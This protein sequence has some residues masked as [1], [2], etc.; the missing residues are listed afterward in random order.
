MQFLCRTALVGLIFVSLAKLVAAQDAPPTPVRYDVDLSDA[1]NHHVTITLSADATGPETEVMMATWTPGSYLIRE[2]ARHID[3]I[4][5]FDPNGKELAIHKTQKNRWKID[6]GEHK[7]FSLRYRIYARERSVR[8][9]WVTEDYAVLNGAPTFITLPTH[10][11][12]AH[13]VTLKLPKPWKRSAT[14]LQTTGS[15][16][17]AY[18]AKDFDELVDSPIVAG[19]MT[20]YPFSVAGKEHQLVNVNDR[21]YWNGSRAVRDL[22]TMVEEHHRLWGNIPYERYLF[23]NV[24]CGGGGGLEHDNSCLLMTSRWSSLSEGGH[25]RWLSLASHE[26]FHTWNVRRLRPK[27]LVKYDYEAEVYTPSLWI[28]EGVTSYYQDLILVRAGL[29]K[30]SEFLSTMSN[31]IGRLQMTE[32]RLRQSLRDSSHDAWIKFYRPDENSRKT[33]ISYYGKGAVVAGLLDAKIRYASGGKHSLDD[34]MRKL[35]EN[36]SGDRGFLPSDFRKI[37]SDLAGVDLNPWF[38]TAVDSTD[39]LDYQELCDCFGLK[40]GNL[41]PTPAKSNTE[42]KP[43]K[44]PND[45][46]EKTTD[47]VAKEKNDD[48]K[49]AKP[50]PWIGVGTRTDNGR[51][52]VSS[53]ETNSP[54]SR[55]GLSLDD[56]LI[57]L[58]GMRLTGSLNLSSK[59]YQVGDHVQLLIAREGSLREVTLTLEAQKQRKSWRLSTYKE[60]SDEQK[61]R[62]ADWLGQDPPKEKEAS[63]KKEDAKKEPTKQ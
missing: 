35:Y 61:K 32:G 39:E 2:Y 52:V 41:S 25:R 6:T 37:C 30:Q 47:K 27:A 43:T 22:A 55:A 11:D 50:T 8:T 28:A 4:A 62:L 15:E 24:I 45:A 13:Q 56:E 34:A 42:S 3:Q 31:G 36:H 48:K 26:F 40:V 57:A 38:A 17:H 20:I 53:V 23:I 51:L 9:N 59:M 7:T 33:Q 18:L 46:S 58:N 44:E 19:K 14:S 1:R 60:A 10:L 54:A 49:E 16:T 21:G 12:R 29:I 63:A 5:A